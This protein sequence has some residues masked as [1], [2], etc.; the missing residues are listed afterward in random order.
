MARMIVPFHRPSLGEEEKREIAEVLDSGWLTSGPKVAQFET[1]FRALTRAPF[2]A[3]VSSATAG[4]HVALEA[5]GVGPGDE[6][7]T[8]PL[9][10]CATV[11]AIGQSG[12]M[13][14]L[15]DIGEDGN[16]D[17]ALVEQKI[18]ART[19][20][21]LPVHL[22]GLPCH[23][24][25]LRGIA[26]KHGLYVVE[27]AAHAAGS[28]YDGAPV[29]GGSDAVVFSFYANKNMTT[30]EGGMVTTRD[31]E[32]DQR[33]RL[34]SLHG[35]DKATWA[36]ES[37]GRSWK[38]EVAEAGF[39]YNLSDLQGAVGLAQLR[40]L[41]GFTA[42]RRRLA[43]FYHARFRGVEELE[44]PAG[45]DDPGHSWHLYALRLRLE[46]LCIDRDGFIEELNRRGIGASVHFIPIP[47]HRAFE[48]LVVDPEL[49]CG[50][51]LGLYPRLLSIPI[52]PSLEDA[53]A[54]FV[55]SAVVDIARTNRRRL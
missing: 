2:A 19:K 41:E 1:E 13:P 10:F 54:E 6:V 48:G 53:Q 32:V 55:A 26:D 12:A 22:G 38:Y 42:A 20:A 11:L 24:R 45:A 40:K 31:R 30:A 35:I 4:M 29:G 46:A 27:D 52:Y 17:P 50:R 15:A 5:L 9:T 7:I 28:C 25:A 51:T 23:L 33:I 21:I 18:T 34:L 3:A 14:V 39:K 37:N 36:R 16:I 43:H 47:L 44:L 49:E 8:T